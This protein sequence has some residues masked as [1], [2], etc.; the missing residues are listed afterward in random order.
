VNLSNVNITLYVSKKAYRIFFFDEDV[1][2]D[3][4][5]LASSLG[6]LVP[7]GLLLAEAL[8]VLGPMVQESSSLH[9]AK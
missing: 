9:H 1:G 2:V 5:V 7:P 3:P 6:G 4:T 8:D